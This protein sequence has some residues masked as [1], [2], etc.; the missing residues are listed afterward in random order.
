MVS[1]ESRWA[2]SVTRGTYD[3]TNQS[4]Y[5]NDYSYYMSRVVCIIQRFLSFHINYDCG[6]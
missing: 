6:H 1:K 2:G 4:C 5:Y 3:D